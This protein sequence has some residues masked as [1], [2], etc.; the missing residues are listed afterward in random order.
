MKAG[1]AAHCESMRRQLLKDASASLRVSTTTRPGPHSLYACNL[2]RLCELGQI[3]VPLHADAAT[4]EFLTVEGNC[5]VDLWAELLLPLVQFCVTTAEAQQL[6][7]KG[8]MFV[9]STE[10]A[11]TLLRAGGA[12]SA[13]GRLL[14]CGAGDGSVTAQLA[15]LADEVVC[16]EV[17][18]LAAARVRSRGWQCTIEEIPAREH[19]AF[20]VVSCLNVVCRAARP[21]QLLRRLRELLAPG[22]VLLLAVV[23]PFDPAVLG[24]GK[25]SGAP[26]EALPSE[27]VDA[28][29]FEEGVVALAV[30]V[31]RPLG[32]RV[33]AVSRVPYYSR[34]THGTLY[35]LDD[36]LLVCQRARD[37]DS[38]ADGI[39]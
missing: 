17:S 25:T 13:L 21:L 38:T 4:W 11:A 14:D 34:G 15:P 20:D 1:E 6:V 2:P 23:L 9:L 28:R 3:F 37:A 32:L 27:L 19:G 31:L 36:A 35:A 18:G 33:S 12:R 24:C 39:R 8:A 5:L 16:T 29:S 22:G 26:L 7:G 10:Q 30:H